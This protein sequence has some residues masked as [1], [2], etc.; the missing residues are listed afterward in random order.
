MSGYA[1]DPR[2]IR[3]QDVE[4]ATEQAFHAEAALSDVDRLLAEVVGTGQAKGVGAVVDAEGR[5]AEI[6][7]G[8]QA[9][10][11]GTDGLRDAI[12]AAV[13]AAQEHARRQADELLREHLRQ[14]VPGIA[15]DVAELRR[16][17]GGLL[18]NNHISHKG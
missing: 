3:P 8:P 16:R 18:E 7:L 11:E 1:I 17:L 9:L 14:A 2:D 10:R 5:V 15:V 13:G 4:R 6:T 12:F